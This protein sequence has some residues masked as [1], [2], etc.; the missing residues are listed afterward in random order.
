MGVLSLTPL[1][2]FPWGNSPRYTL[3]KGWVT[4]TI[5]FEDLFFLPDSN[6]KS[7]LYRMNF[8]ESSG[9]AFRA[10]LIT[11]S[12]LVL[13]LLLWGTFFLRILRSRLLKNCMT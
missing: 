8:S 12:L 10:R 6:P 2:L 1:P 11:K 13:I 3:C 7:S 5:G 9:Q 4:P